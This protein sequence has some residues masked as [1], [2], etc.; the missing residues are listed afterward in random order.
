MAG[1]RVGIDGEALRA[2]LSGVG[3][4]VLQLARGLDEL[5][6]DASFFAYSRLPSARLVLPSPRWVLRV[7]PSRTLRRLPSFAWLKTRG[8]LLC[9]RDTLDVFWA[10]RTL[11]PRLGRSVRTV[12]TVH[13]LNHLIVPET[14][15]LPTRWSHRLWLRGDL[16]A[17]D[18]VV[19]NSLG[20]A[21]RLANLLGI[22]VHGV[23]TP[24]LHRRYC[25]LEQ[26][27]HP[28]ARVALLRLGIKPP[29]LL[30]VATLEPRKNV[31]ALVQAFLSL[32]R[33]DELPDCSLVLAGARGWHDKRLM[34]WLRSARDDGVILP[35]Y[36]P[37]ALMPALYGFAMALVCPSIYEGF[38]MPV[39][40]ARACGT[41]VV[42]SDTPE[43][44]E[45][46]GAHAVLIQPTVSGIRSGLQRAMTLAPQIE[47]GL[48]ER[49][50]WR[51]Q[52]QLLAALMTR[53]S[54]P[55]RFANALD[56]PR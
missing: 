47:P 42:V 54:T 2:P 39:L 43:L 25:P 16:K 10:G 53:R 36:V 20:T 17:A 18:V 11:H 22:A 6:P 4:Y 30:S 21:Q 23:V 31:E 56:A 34:N 33:R 49:H 44:R 46:G 24:G 51:H 37:D 15:E 8:A 9:Q 55:L 28:A 7:E 3:Q 14:M 40:E 41:R 13:D 35:G 12:C 50:S 48:T 32:R 1:L 5:L 19:A 29:Y 26:A 45:A 38:G 27:D 52:A